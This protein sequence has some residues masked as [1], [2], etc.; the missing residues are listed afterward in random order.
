M[1]KKI[2]NIT[3]ILI[4]IILSLS[5]ISA[6]IIEHILNHKPCNLCLYQRIPYII[7]IFFI[8]LIFIFKRN[9]NI[10]LF[11]LFVTFLISSILAFYHFGIEQGF[12]N[13]SALCKNTK[14]SDSLNKEEIL[15]QLKEINVSCKDVPFKVFGLSLAT[16]NTFFSIV[17]SVIFYKLLKNNYEKNR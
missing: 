6:F 9:N 1:S 17:L 7:S 12:F 11:L 8:L 3:L 5:L 13:E 10:F 2:Y 15:K 14:V 4:L 16:I